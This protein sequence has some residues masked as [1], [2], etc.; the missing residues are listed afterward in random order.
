MNTDSQIARVGM[1]D[2]A[3]AGASGSTKLGPS[4]GA[5]PY[6]PPLISSA[7]GAPL[8]HGPAAGGQMRPSAGY[9]LGTTRGCHGSRPRCGHAEPA[10][11]RPL[12]PSDAG[13]ATNPTCSVPIPVPVK[14]TPA[15]RLHG[16]QGDAGA[17]GA[18]DAGSAL[19]GRTDSTRCAEREFAISAA[20]ARD[21]QEPIGCRWIHGDT[22]EPDWRYCEAPRVLGK[23]WCTTHLKRVFVPRGAA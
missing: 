12:D 10:A 15:F 5:A 6:P 2:A 18:R 4:T 1:R 20:G 9:I 13:S 16:K 22:Q 17:K 21:P 14:E 8:E 23:S 19:D 3:P 7:A 11:Q